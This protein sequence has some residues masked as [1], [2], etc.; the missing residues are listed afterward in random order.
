MKT[1]I[2]FFVMFCLFVSCNNSGNSDTK[3][4]TTTSEYKATEE[5]Q[6][7]I[8]I[9]YDLKKGR[10]QGLKVGTKAP[11]F[12]LKAPDG[13]TVKLS[14]TLKDGPVALLFYRG[15]WCPV[16]IRYFSAFM[17]D[18]PQ[19]EAKGVK[20]LAVSPE[21]D[22][23]IDKTK[24][25]AKTNFTILHD[26]DYK[27]MEDYD[28]L[29]HVTEAYQKKIR[30]KFNTDIAKNNGKPDARLPVPATY[31]IGQDGLIKYVQFDL[32]Y[33]NRASV[34]EILKHI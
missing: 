8:N 17:K 31:V 10:P 18:A 1:T 16:C 5:E 30:D 15:E 22:E 11:N 9:G 24:T 27:V 29:F 3:Q 25:K 26:P 6:Q 13:S 33:K 23:N 7:W 28:V 34:K 21:T 32:N 2:T 4:T 20:V 12:Q 19:L 14:E